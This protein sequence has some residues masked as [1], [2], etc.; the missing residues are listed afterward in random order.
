M[1]LI[2][3]KSKKAF[4][5]NVKTEMDAHPSKEKRAQNLAIA[6]SVQRRN[7]RKKKALGGAVEETPSTKISP[8]AAKMEAEHEHTE[9]CWV[10]DE[11][12]CEHE[13]MANGGA[14]EETPSTEVSDMEDE[15]ENAKEA[16]MLRAE[17]EREALA[18][19][20]EAEDDMEPDMPHVGDD[21]E[22]SPSEDEFMS[23]H[24]AEGGD[25]DDHYESIADA[26]L[27]KRRRAKMMAEGGMVDLEANSE[28][29]PN[30]EDQMSF[31]ANGKEQ[32]D[33]RQLKAQPM[34]SNEHGDA[35]KSDSHDRIDRM[36]RKVKKQRGM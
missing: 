8:E 31:K 34:D 21:S 28:E 9:E 13:M 22:M 1:P 27:K 24:M 7:A 30:Q 11:L 36:R 23:S 26:I 14:V 6:Y 16:K 4:E 29:S 33:L 12:H 35:I 2:Q 18:F 17:H 3:S 20:G 19:G 5:K 10:G 32:Y 25:V 15:M